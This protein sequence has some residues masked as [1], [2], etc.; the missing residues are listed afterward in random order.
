MKT[1]WPAESKI[2]TIWSF[3]ENVCW[4]LKNEISLL[5][6]WYLIIPGHSNMSKTCTSSLPYLRTALSKHV[7]IEKSEGAL[8]LWYHTAKHCTV[9]LGGYGQAL[10]LRTHPE[11]KERKVHRRQ[12]ETLTASRWCALCD[13][14]TVYKQFTL[15]FVQE[16]FRIWVLDLSV[17][18]LLW[19]EDSFLCSEEFTQLKSNAYSWSGPGIQEPDSKN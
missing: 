5:Q 18:V 13:C 19:R 3:T 2:F 1:V 9:V 10:P 11:L 8:G 14:C 7:N 12:V 17:K 15:W 16:C 4:P 6:L